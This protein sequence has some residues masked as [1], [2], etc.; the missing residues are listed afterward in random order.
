MKKENRSFRVAGCI[1]LVICL[2][3]F[4]SVFIWGGGL[5][6]HAVDEDPMDTIGEGEYTWTL[7]DGVYTIYNKGTPTSTKVKSGKSV[8]QQIDKNSVKKVVLKG[9][10][11]LGTLCQQLGNN[12][13][14]EVDASD[15][16]FSTVQKVNQLFYNT[17]IQEIDMSEWDMSSCT[18]YSQMFNGSH[19]QSVE[20]FKNTSS[21]LLN[22]DYMFE[23]SDLKSITFPADLNWNIKS[24]QG[25]VMHSSCLTDVDISAF[26]IDE[27]KTMYQD[28]FNC[29]SLTNLVLPSDVHFVANENGAFV[30]LISNTSISNITINNWDMSNCSSLPVISTAYITANYTGKTIAPKSVA[31]AFSNTNQEKI[32]LSDWDFSNTTDFSSMFAGSKAKEI[33]L[34]TIDSGSN[35]ITANRMFSNCSNLKNLDL[36]GW[37]VNKSANFSNFLEYCSSLENVKFSKSFNLGT[38]ASGFFNYC[39]KLST[40]DISGFSCDSDNGIVLSNFFNGCSSLEEYKFPAEG[41]IQNATKIDYMFRDCA[42]LKEIKLPEGEYSKLTD[43]SGMLTNCN[44]IK[45]FS[46]PEGTYGKLT[47]LTN[48]FS[49]CTSLEKADMHLVKAPS[50]NNLQNTFYNCAKLY[51]VKLGD[52]TL[53]ENANWAGVF[54]NCGSLASVDLSS[55][56]INRTNKCNF[57]SGCNSLTRIYTPVGDGSNISLTSPQ[58]TKWVDENGETV[59]AFPNSTESVELKLVGDDSHFVCSFYQ[60]DKNNDEY[61]LKGNAIVT[62]KSGIIS[63][64]VVPDDI[65]GYRFSEWVVDDNGA[66]TALGDYDFDSNKSDISLYSKYDVL[67]SKVTLKQD[68]ATFVGLSSLTATYGENMPVVNSLPA[69]KGYDFAGFYYGDK[70]YIN[71]QGASVNKFDIDLG[72]VTF[73]AHWNERT[74]KPF[75]IS[76]LSS[77]YGEAEII[78]DKADYGEFSTIKV[79]ANE[80]YSVKALYVDDNRVIFSPVDDVA[81]YDILDIKSNHTVKADFEKT[82]ATISFESGYGA[83]TASRMIAVDSKLGELPSLNRA[84]YKLLGFSP[85]KDGTQFYTAETVINSPDDIT[86]YAV[87]EPDKFT[88]NL[89]AGEGKIKASSVEMKYGENFTLET[90]LRGGYKF[91]GWYN[92]DTLFA[93]SGAYT[94]DKGFNLTA[95]YE[96]TE[97]VVNTS[98]NGITLGTVSQNSSTGRYK[99]GE[100]AVIT[101]TPA[102]NCYLKSLTVN[103]MA[104]P[105]NDVYEFTVEGD[106]DV[107]AEFASYIVKLDDNKPT[108]KVSFYYY[109]DCVEVNSNSFRAEKQMPQ[110]GKEYIVREDNIQLNSNENA[111]YT[112]KE[113][114]GSKISSVYVDGNKIDSVTGYTF[115]DGK[116]H[117]VIINVTGREDIVIGAVKDSFITLYMDEKAVTVTTNTRVGDNQ[118]VYGKQYVKRVDVPT[119]KY[120]TYSIAANEGF[121]LGTVYVDGQPVSGTEF[122]F[123]DGL[124][125][126]IIINMAAEEEISVDNPGNYKLNPSPDGN[127]NGNDDD[128]IVPEGYMDIVVNGKKLIVKTDEILEAFPDNADGSFI[129]GWKKKDGTFIDVNDW[130]KI[131]SGAELIPVYH[132]ITL[133]EKEKYSLADFYKKLLTDYLEANPKG[134]YKFKVESIDGTNGK[135]SVVSKSNTFTAKKAG[136]VTVKLLTKNEAGIFEEAAGAPVIT[137]AIV[138]PQISAIT[139]DGETVSANICDAIT[140]T[141]GNVDYNP[142]KCKFKIESKSNKIVNIDE[143]GVITP[144]KK[145]KCKIT[146]SYKTVSSISASGLPKYTTIKKKIKV[147]VKSLPA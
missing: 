3:C 109:K 10:G 41:F 73:E 135:G 13:Y 16:D 74:T 21:E 102:K 32:D 34:P 60:G 31:S 6:V 14:V 7:D 97:Y 51:D 24:M 95:K 92:G 90:P 113:L 94:Y 137:I 48:L 53:A 47:S 79:T 2:M 42:S 96:P 142:N 59:T 103:G 131:K 86:L 17:W 62:A 114:A 71:A 121:T 49:G 138:K 82:K 38:N 87:W 144:L 91:L 40:I 19:L 58:Y 126:E 37:T 146:V 11:Y 75:T 5:Y 78:N 45:E 127:N 25:I 136:M 80:G 81:K 120:V 141:G 23:Y 8:I 123:S 112:F 100:K 133:Q 67:K 70:Q 111:A 143:S 68:D 57:L 88:V 54:S 22:V 56:K 33:I 66:S 115:K 36:A 83:P 61:R 99:Y 52:F 76:F 35:M 39:K 140:F 27:C 132:F 20:W 9:Y 116:D 65:T 128:D 98:T 130:K 105:I 63:A 101:V 30:S 1:R 119:E 50:L 18:D 46:F 134:K 129:T 69:R 28:F 85:I 43:V 147:T 108:F 145:G 122:G 125:H 117:D 84:H 104:K 110:E 44:L 12:Q 26:N 55:V 124:N 118:S 64:T 107:E 77:D 89:D 139:F 72:E 4:F 15:Y 29:N 93:S 106:T